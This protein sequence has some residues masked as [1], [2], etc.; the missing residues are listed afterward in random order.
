VFEKNR[1]KLLETVRVEQPGPGG[2]RIEGMHVLEWER[3]RENE[4]AAQLIPA[5]PGGVWPCL[6]AAVSPLSLDPSSAC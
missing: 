1:F 3:P 5:L 2:G 6:V 4:E